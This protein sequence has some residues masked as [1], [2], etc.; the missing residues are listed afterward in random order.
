MRTIFGKAITNAIC[1]GVK[2]ISSKNSGKYARKKAFAKLNAANKP[3]TPVAIQNRLLAFPNEEVL[4]GI[5]IGKHYKWGWRVPEEVD[6]K[7]YSYHLC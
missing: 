5:V 2:L 7:G 4:L 3:L 1:T 6:G